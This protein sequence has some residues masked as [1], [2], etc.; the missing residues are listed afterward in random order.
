MAL[1][2]TVLELTHRPHVQ[3]SVWCRCALAVDPRSSIMKLYYVPGACSLSVHIVLREAGLP[4]EAV[5]VR[6][7]PDAFKLKNLDDGTDF[8]TINPLGYVPALGLD[9]GTVLTEGPAIVQFIADQVPNAA[10][11]PLNGTVGRAKMQGWLNFI[12]TELHKGVAP[13]FNPATPTEYRPMVLDKQLSRLTWVDAQLAGKN[14]LMGDQF[15]VADP[16]LFVVTNWAKNLQL[17]IT[18]LPNLSAFRERMANRPAVK[19]AMTAEGLLGI[20]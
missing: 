9:D 4:F 2:Q 1:R 7:D 8:Y 13:L 10:L 3:E 14:Y 6:P 5:R 18:G 17:D 11:A 19:A 16:Y 12:S 20:A 15:S